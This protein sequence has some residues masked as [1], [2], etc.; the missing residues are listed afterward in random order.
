MRYTSARIE[1]PSMEALIKAANEGSAFFNRLAF[2]ECYQSRELR[3][4]QQC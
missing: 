2:G 4:M 3:E 1:F